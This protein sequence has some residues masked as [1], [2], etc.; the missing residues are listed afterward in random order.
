MF[1]LSEE[2]EKAIEY[3]KNNW[4][5]QP[6]T[7]LTG[8]GGSG[9]SAI[10]S[11]LIK[12]LN[13]SKNE[14][15]YCA[16]TG[17]AALTLKK[18]GVNAQTIHH[19]I[20]NTKK[21]KKTGKFRSIL[22]YKL[23]RN[24][25]LIIIDE[26]SFVD[27]KTMQD[28]LSFHIPII[29]MGDEGQLPPPLGKINKYML[30]PDVRLTKIFRQKDGN[31]IIDFASNL[32]KGIFD[33]SFNDDNVKCFDSLTL[34]MCLWA[35]QILCS[36]NRDKDEINRAIREYKGFKSHIPEVGDKLM[37]LKNNWEN[38]PISGEQYELVNGMTGYVEEILD[39]TFSPTYNTMT[40]RFS[41]EFDRNIVYE[42]TID[43]NPFL[44]RKSRDIQWLDVFDYGYACTIHK[45]QS[46]QW[47]KVL[48]YAKNGFGDR[49][50]LFYTAATRAID[51]LVW[52]G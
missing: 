20:Y 44:G 21:D 13:L 52:V 11:V 34:N 10:I 27:E 41:L 46:S 16:Y 4:N 45:S 47:S 8:Y 38:F 51:K 28:L 32:R 35:D 25:K 12:Q 26:G 50:K 42:T 37:C 5:K 43:L 15:A 23:D 18:R 6:V 9:K 48:V 14:V 19:L 39:S 7:V 31:T 33:Y 22:K 36:T 17:C 30:K 29:M 2:Q 40:I 49:K 3:I 24:Y 1:K